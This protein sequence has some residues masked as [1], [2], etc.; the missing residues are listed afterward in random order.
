[1][2]SLK[3]DIMF[4]WDHKEEYKLQTVNVA[5]QKAGQKICKGVTS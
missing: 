2:T 4:K 5:L 1:M 3:C